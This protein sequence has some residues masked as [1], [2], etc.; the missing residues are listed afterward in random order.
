LTNLENKMPH[1]SEPRSTLPNQGKVQNRLAAASATLCDLLCQ[2]EL[3]QLRAAVQE[4]R[5]AG[6]AQSNLR[7]LI[8]GV[9]RV[10]A[11]L[12]VYGVE[13]DINRLV[14]NVIELME[15]TREIVGS[16]TGA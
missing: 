2:G 3:D 8:Q 16:E 5:R 1:L 14:T 13:P 11:L 7:P 4:I 6:C 15:I 9:E 12:D 10:E